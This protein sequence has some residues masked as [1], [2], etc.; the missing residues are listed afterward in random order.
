MKST[1]RSL[2]QYFSEHA[3]GRRA[4]SIATPR[5]SSWLSIPN[6]Y[7]QELEPSV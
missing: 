6:S 1:E 7:L 3:N 4:T 5:Y 2:R